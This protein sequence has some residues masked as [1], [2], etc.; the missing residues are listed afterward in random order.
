[1]VVD[2]AGSVVV[3]DGVDDREGDGEIERLYELLAD[4]STTS[5]T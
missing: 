5:G 3:A 1:M 2:F 4:H